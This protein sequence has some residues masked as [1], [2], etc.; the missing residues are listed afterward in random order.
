MVH[1]FDSF[2]PEAL[3]KLIYRRLAGVIIEYLDWFD[4]I[5]RYDWPNTLFYLDPPYFGVEDYCGKDLFK[6]KDYQTMSKLLAQLKGKFLVS[7]N[8]VSGMR[9]TFSQFKIKEVSIS[10]TCGSKNQTLVQK[11]IISNCDF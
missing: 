1:G 2:K 6:R 10:Y 4:F 8:D 5:K 7:L 9:K 3:L 11:L